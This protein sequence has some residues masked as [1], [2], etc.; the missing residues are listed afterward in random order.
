MPG[1]N[2]APCYVENS[3]EDPETDE[4]MIKTLCL[5]G[6]KIEIHQDFVVGRATQFCGATPTVVARELF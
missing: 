3:V 2:R 5:P 6:G 4:M 1:F